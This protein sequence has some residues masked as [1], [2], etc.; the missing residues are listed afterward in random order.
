MLLDVVMP[1]VSGIE[2]CR[3]LKG[4][5][6]TRLTPVVLI[7]G[8]HNRAQRL[9]GLEAGADDFSTSRSTCRSFERESD[10][11]FASNVSP[12]ISSRPKP[13]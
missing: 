13:S 12:T 4:H 5:S 6:V 2:V 8:N 7:T 1:G 11:S 10:H 3:E 9:L